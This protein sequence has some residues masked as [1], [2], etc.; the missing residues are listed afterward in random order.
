MISSTYKNDEF[1]EKI[2]IYKYTFFLYKENIGIS[3][4]DF[5]DLQNPIGHF[6]PLLRNSSKALMIS[7]TKNPN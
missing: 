6:N 7:H 4:P 3:P 1:F 2:F 5:E